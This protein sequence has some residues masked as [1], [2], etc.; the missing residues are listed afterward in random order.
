[1]IDLDELYK[2]GKL[3]A[4]SIEEAEQGKG[5]DEDGNLSGSETKTAR[6]SGLR[7]E[8]PR[9]QNTGFSHKPHAE[10]NSTASGSMYTGKGSRRGKA[11]KTGRKSKEKK[12]PSVDEAAVRKLAR[13]SMSTEELRLF[14]KQKEY[15]DEEISAELKELKAHHYL[16]DRRFAWEYLQYAFS[17]NRSRMRAFSELRK[18][19]VSEADMQNAFMDYEDLEGSL[20]ER[21]MA[22][23][24][25]EKVLRMADLTAD[26]P[27]PEKIRG[28]IARRLSA[29][30]F[31]SSLIWD[32]LGELRRG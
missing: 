29:R 22:E 19:G 3:T 9:R 24:E 17:Q 26:D 4:A 14:L 23:K 13:K 21:A 27:I 2:Q 15:A 1:M 5:I 16:D 32:M 7:K 8:V 18:K 31:S 20:N 11:E 10:E 28:R 12:K 30:G 6:P 25:M